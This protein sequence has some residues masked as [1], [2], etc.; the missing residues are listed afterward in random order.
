MEATSTD[1]TDAVIVAI[2]DC[3]PPN[4]DLSGIK[5]LLAQGWDINEDMGNMGDAL[6]YVFKSSCTIQQVLC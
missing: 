5:K 4:W 1:I 3:K 6:M 2:K